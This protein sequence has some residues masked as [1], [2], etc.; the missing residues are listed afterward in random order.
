MGGAAAL[1]PQ[2]APSGTGPRQFGIEGTLKY[3][4]RYSQMEDIY[5]SGRGVQELS[6][7]SGDVNFEN[8]SERH[9]LSITFGGGYNWRLGGV[10]SEDGVFE[11]LNL[12]QAFVGK[13]WNL[14]IGDATTYR[15]QLP[16]DIGQP[17]TGEPIGNPNPPEVPV[18]ALNT[19]MVNNNLSG[20]FNRQISS[21]LMFNSDGDYMMLRYPE[22]NGI[23]NTRY[24]GDAGITW[25]LNGRN[26]IQALYGYN[27]FDY[28]G[29]DVTIIANGVMAGAVRRWTPNLE[30]SISAGP[31]WVTSSNFLLEP[32]ELTYQ[33]NGVATYIMRHGT[34]TAMY[35][36]SVAG[37][38]GFILGSTVDTADLSLEHKF[39]TRW[40]AEASLGYRRTERISGDAGIASK[41]ASAQASRRIGR[42]FVVFGNYTAALQSH[43]G[44]VAAGVLNGLWQRVSIGAGFTPP[45]IHLGR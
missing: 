44:D 30:T 33:A 14:S 20:K 41:I 3:A 39:R 6:T 38:S 45:A 26:S 1:W 42:R 12:R 13:H 17:G 9:P 18:I 31:Q 10:R 5:S 16:G 34:A 4:L 40:T 23:E 29:Y 7:I 28:P 27:R 15:K 36:R 35:T 2:A 8:A 11:N 22:G 25:R 19:V 32:S 37:G 21:A 43:N 24:R